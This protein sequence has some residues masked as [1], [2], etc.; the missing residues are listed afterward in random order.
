MQVFFFVKTYIVH[1]KTQN[2]KE[3]RNPRPQAQQSRTLSLRRHQIPMTDCSG[4]QYP[5]T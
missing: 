3:I 4:Y 5:K 1:E 2:P